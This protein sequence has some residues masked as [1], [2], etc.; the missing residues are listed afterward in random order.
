MYKGGLT[1][2]KTYLEILRTISL[3]SQLIFAKD[4]LFGRYSVKSKRLFK[5]FSHPVKHTSPLPQSPT[6]PYSALSI[7]FPFSLY[8]SLYIC[9]F[10]FT[11]I[12]LSFVQ[13][14]S[15]FSHIHQPPRSQEVTS[16]AFDFE[17]LE[18]PRAKV[19]KRKGNT[20]LY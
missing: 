4:N 6:F 18:I 15:P 9:L 8:F 2:V 11:Y 13:H 1:T 7:Y 12:S 20:H 16:P 19:E 5:I 3:N 17:T 14:F 10:F